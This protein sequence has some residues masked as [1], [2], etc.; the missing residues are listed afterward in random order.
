[1]DFFFISALTEKIQ[2]AGDIALAGLNNANGSKASVRQFI[3]SK[4]PQ[5]RLY[6]IVR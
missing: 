2:T 4:E 5:R 1:M 3:Y 6:Q